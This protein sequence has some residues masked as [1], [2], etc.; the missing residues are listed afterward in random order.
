MRH[1]E[2]KKK[3]NEGLADMADMVERDHEVQM[4]RAE[5]YKIGKYRYF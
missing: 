5:L 2:I 4:A 3:T 1:Q